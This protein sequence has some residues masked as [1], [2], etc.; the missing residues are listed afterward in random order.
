[1]VL[2][3]HLK[4]GWR[5]LIPSSSVFT[6]DINPSYSCSHSVC[7][8]VLFAVIS[9]FLAWLSGLSNLASVLFSSSLIHHVV[10]SVHCFLNILW[11]FH[12]FWDFA[13]TFPLTKNASPSLPW[14]TTIP[15]TWLVWTS[16][17]SHRIG[18]SFLRVP[19]ALWVEDLWL[20]FIEFH[21]NSLS[22][23]YFNWRLCWCPTFTCWTCESSMLPLGLPNLRPLDMGLICGRSL[24]NTRCKWN[25]L[26]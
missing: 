26:S 2:S 4:Q 22:I 13:H 15:M 18:Y 21:L 8:V 10:H 7:P 12:T 14:H 24:R 9:T 16:F 17:S 19:I 5:H 6:P 23:L 1:M 3:S 11:L 25:I 20:L